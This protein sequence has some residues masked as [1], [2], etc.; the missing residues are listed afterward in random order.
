MKSIKLTGKELDS[1]GVVH[2]RR[3]LNNIID[4][5]L[6]RPVGEM[7]LWE[8]EKLI[9]DT[10]AF[11]WLITYYYLKDAVFLKF[12]IKNGFKRKAKL[13]MESTDNMTSNFT[14]VKFKVDSY[15]KDYAFNHTWGGTDNMF[16]S[17]KIIEF[18]LDSLPSG[19]TQILI[20]PPIGMSDAKVFIYRLY[21][22][23]YDVL[24]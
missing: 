3:I 21:L 17:I 22:L 15:E 19:H 8:G 14:Y 9:T 5:V 7:T 11:Q 6:D 12:P 20:T 2:K 23:L 10:G 1:S 24:E 4:S 16:K 13:I 18:D